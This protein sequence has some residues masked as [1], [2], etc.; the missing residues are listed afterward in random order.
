MTS[1][2][3]RAPQRGLADPATPSEL[4]RLMP[5]RAFLLFVFASTLPLAF[6]AEPSEDAKFQALVDKIWAW[7]MHEFPEWATS[8]GKR[9]GLDRWTDES[10][11]AMDRRDAHTR[12]VLA[13]LEKIDAKKLGEN[14]GSTASCCAATSNRTSRGRNS[15]ASCSRSPARRRP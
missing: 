6:A 15:P 10:P 12:E 4:G 14:G 11:E 3:S 7:D 8:L 13:E 5:L 2:A 1:A 9:E